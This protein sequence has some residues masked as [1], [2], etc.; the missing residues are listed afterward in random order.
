MKRGSWCRRRR[1][2]FDLGARA[3]GPAGPGR[4][5]KRHLMVPLFCDWNEAG[6][7]AL[8][9]FRR[10]VF[11]LIL[12]LVPA[13]SGAAAAA[14]GKGGGGEGRQSESC[15]RDGDEVFHTRF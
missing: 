7:L 13:F 14:A 9:A 6:A 1:R 15:D 8:G 2:K 12:G 10:F 11:A 4:K 3:A 5:K